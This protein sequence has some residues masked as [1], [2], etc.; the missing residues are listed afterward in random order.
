MRTKVDKEGVP[1]EG[2]VWHVLETK[3]GIETA[4]FQ[5]WQSVGCRS[6]N[7]LKRWSIR[8]RKLPYILSDWGLVGEESLQHGD[9]VGCPVWT[10]GSW[11]SQIDNYT[12]EV[13]VTMKY[14][15]HTE[16][17]IK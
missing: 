11:G 17:L 8:V 4:H 12:Q 13:V 14:W 9:G 15:L 6:L 1:L 2:L 3:Q 10:A 7:R 16:E 5:R